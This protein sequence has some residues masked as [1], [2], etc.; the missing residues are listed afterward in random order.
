MNRRRQ[1]QLN[2]A[3]ERVQEIKKK[4]Q[5]SQTEQP[6]FPWQLMQL[7]CYEERFLYKIYMNLNLTQIPQAIPSY[8]KV[9]KARKPKN[10]FDDIPI[11]VGV[12]EI[13]QPEQIFIKKNRICAI[14][15][16]EIND[17][18]LIKILKC[19]HYFH[20]ECIKDWLIIKAEC[21]T[22]RNKIEQY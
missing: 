18:N 21:P 11:L 2:N 8:L 13:P 15:L 22:C 14:C 3:Y 4:I 20:N 9:V 1:L 10:W 19:N 12:D 6:R 17:K 5:K 16:S 7:M